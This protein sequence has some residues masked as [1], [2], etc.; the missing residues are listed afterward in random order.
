MRQSTM[1]WAFLSP[2]G[3]GIVCGMA[4]VSVNAVESNGSDEADCLVLQS[5]KND[6][7]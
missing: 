5:A 7:V 4:E 3:L 2:V 6:G 1:R